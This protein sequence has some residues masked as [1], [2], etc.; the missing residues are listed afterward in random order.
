MVETWLN[1]DERENQNARSESSILEELNNHAPTLSQD[2]K[3]VELV[4]GNLPEAVDIIPTM[5]TSSG[6]D[7]K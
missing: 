7:A 5:N 6:T 1:N 2:T 4:E 3:L